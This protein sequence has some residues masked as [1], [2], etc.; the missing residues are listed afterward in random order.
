MFTRI[1]TYVLAFVMAFSPVMARADL[2]GVLDQLASGTV[3]NV[4]GPGRFQSQARTS[5]VMGGF[6]MRVPV[7]S[8]APTLVSFTPPRVDASCAGV[9]AFFGGFSFIS[10]KEFEQLLKNISAGVA[11]GFVAHLALKT[12]CPQCEAVVQLMQRLNQIASMAAKDSCKYGAKL[13]EEFSNWA[14]LNGKTGDQNAKCAATA[15][16]AS[17]SGAVSDMF[18]GENSLCTSVANMNKYLDDKVIKKM[19][20]WSNAGASQAVVKAGADA[21]KLDL[22]MKNRTWVVSGVFFP[23]T[24]PDSARMRQLMINLLGTTIYPDSS[25]DNEIVGSCVGYSMKADRTINCPAQMEAKDMMDLFMCGVER[26]MPAD[27]AESVKSGCKDTV[28]FRAAEQSNRKVWECIENPAVDCMNLNSVALKD[29]ALFTGYTGLT[30]QV[31]LTLREAVRRVVANERLWDSSNAGDVQGKR[32][33]ALIQAAPYPIYQAINAAAVYPAASADILDSLTVL[34]AE[35]LAMSYFE[36]YFRLMGRNGAGSD[37]NANTLAAFSEAMTALSGR[38]DRL[39][40]RTATNISVQEGITQSIRSLN[41][42][43][44]RQVMTDEIF[45]ANQFGK[46]LSSMVSQGTRAPA[47]TGATP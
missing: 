36:E 31:N 25:G 2:S 17:L 6:E 47:S 46:G 18:S 26:Y 8:N 4:N 14:G 9:S 30:F 39:K 21:A 24:M 34:I 20:D 40:Q 10:G 13:A 42:A 29:S 12:L 28:G 45:G 16:Y 23:E 37:V 22:A 1:L 44:Q 43:I 5:M 11:L 33:V 32:I 15:D 3:A 27:A 38:V 35:Q 19:Q 41:Q 7:S